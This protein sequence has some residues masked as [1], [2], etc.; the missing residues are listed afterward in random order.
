MDAAFLSQ[1]LL[2]AMIWGALY[3]TV[4][5]R[6][7]P[8]KPTHIE[9]WPFRYLSQVL[10]RLLVCLHKML[11]YTDPLDYYSEES[12]PTARAAPRAT[13]IASVFAGESVKA[14]YRA[15]PPSL[16]DAVW[17]YALGHVVAGAE[18]P[19]EVDALAQGAL[20][21]ARGAIVGTFEGALR[22]WLLEILDTL[23]GRE[24][25]SG[26]VDAALLRVARI[27][28]EIVDPKDFPALPHKGPGEFPQL[29]LRVIMERSAGRSASESEGAPPETS[30]GAE[31]TQ[32]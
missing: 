14:L 8:D 18:L 6:M 27:L 26:P 21:A 13:A 23:A 3:A 11:K 31:Q 10:K 19:H 15:G 22:G 4:L 16:A 5:S 32:D 7:L 12:A 24:S 25:V 1:C 20:L 17:R 29:T 30:E 28:K 9:R 2:N